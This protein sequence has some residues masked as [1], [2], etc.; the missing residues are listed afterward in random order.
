MAGPLYFVLS[1]LLSSSFFLSFF[2]A[3]LSGRRLDVHT[4]I[5]LHSANLECRSEMCCTQLAGNTGPKKKSPKNHHLGTIAQH[6][7]AISS[8]LRHLSTI[9]KKLLNSNVSPTCPH[10]PTPRRTS[11]WDLL[12]SLRHPLKFQRV[13]RLGGVT[14]RHSNSGRQPNCGVEQRAP[15]IFDR[16]AITLGIGPYF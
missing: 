6:C 14:A 11:G 8:Q 9:G 5:L 7:R 2:V 12:A 3:Y 1:F 13:S 4:T 10:G 16:A 15:P